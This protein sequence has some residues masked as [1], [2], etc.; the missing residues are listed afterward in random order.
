M[1]GE[2]E[3]VI[4]EPSVRNALHDSAVMSVSY[5]RKN[6]NRMRFGEYRAKGMLVALGL[7]EGDA[8]WAICDR[9]K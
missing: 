1:A 8:K 6:L 9:M 4:Q 7:I 3:E 5:F 2:I